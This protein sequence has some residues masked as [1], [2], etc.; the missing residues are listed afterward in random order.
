MELGIVKDGAFVIKETMD[1]KPGACVDTA[2]GVYH[3]F[4]AT[5]DDARIFN[6]VNKFT[7]N[8][9]AKDTTL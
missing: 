2:A 6:I 3:Q 5:S 1:L 7:M 9:D 4:V 8:P